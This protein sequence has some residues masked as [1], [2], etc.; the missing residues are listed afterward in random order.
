MLVIRQ[1]QIAALA[2]PSREGMKLRMRAQL[3]RYWAPLCEQLDAD[4]VASLIEHALARC[5]H[6][7]IGAENDQMRF[8]NAMA[9]LGAGFD[10][11]YAWARSCL[12]NHNVRSASRMDELCETIFRKV[13]S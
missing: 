11:E 6:H 1:E 5:L 7:G 10:E 3:Q 13:N 8:L 2:A 4:G 12:A 9:L